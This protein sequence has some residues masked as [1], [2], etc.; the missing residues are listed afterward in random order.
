MLDKTQYHCLRCG[1]DWLSA[2]DSPDRCPNCKSQRW[3]KPVLYQSFHNDLRGRR[4]K[5]P[6]P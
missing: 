3:D 1:N 6:L 2:S 4:R 5:C